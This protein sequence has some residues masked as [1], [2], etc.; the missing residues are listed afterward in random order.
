MIKRL[1]KARRTAILEHLLALEKQIREEF[2]DNPPPRRRHLSESDLRS[3]R[4]AGGAGESRAIAEE[5]T[6]RSVH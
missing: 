3:S 2:G 5:L 4:P 6:A 1:T